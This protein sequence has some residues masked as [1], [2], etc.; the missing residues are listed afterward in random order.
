MHEE[1]GGGTEWQRAEL[2][3]RSRGRKRT[4][5]SASDGKAP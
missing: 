4:D 1:R 2:G 5:P 3:A